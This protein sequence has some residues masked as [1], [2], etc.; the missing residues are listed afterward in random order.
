M[1]KVKKFAALF[2]ALT[3]LIC[4]YTG[5]AVFAVDSPSDFTIDE[6]GVLTEYSGAGGDVI[7]PDTVKEIG[8]Y[9]FMDCQSI[10]SVTIPEGVTKIQS[11]AFSDCT[12]LISGALPATLTA[13][14]SGAFYN[15]P[16]LSAIT[17]P[18]SSAYFCTDSAVLFSKDKTVLVLYPAALP[19]STYTV[20]TGVTKIADTAFSNAAN[21]TDVTLQDGVT[22][23]GRSAFALCQ[24]LANVSIP[25]SVTEIGG[26]AFEET[27]WLN[28]NT[29]PFVTV[30]NILVR[31]HGADS[32]AAVPADV[33]NIAE[34]AFFQCNVTSISIPNTV[35]KIGS[36]AFA[37]CLEL[38]SVSLPSSLTK[39]DDGLFAMCSKLNT[40]TIPAKVT[41]IGELAF[42]GCAALIN[43]NIPAHVS[44]IGG[45]AFISCIGLTDVI[46]PN[47]VTDIGDMAFA[48]CTNLKS[49][50]IPGSVT[51]I[52][53]SV[54]A[55]DSNV[56]VYG[57]AGSAAQTYASNSGFKFSPLISY[58][59][60]GYRGTVT[61]DTQSYDMAPKNIYDIGVKFAGNGNTKTFKVVSSR[62][63]I[64]SV[65]KL[66]NGNYRITGLK[67]GTT[68]IVCTIY[69]GTKEITHASI[70]VTVTAG[71]KQH[72][73]A[74]RS[75]SYFN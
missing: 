30:N 61:L 43:I 70:K 35:T 28:N 37:M 36:G 46:L 39:I 1:K 73:V 23:I 64:A 57:I 8:N 3:L 59:G 22:T 51:K 33:T 13:I 18:D 7:I 66:P 25:A 5:T 6:N 74:T 50:S 34:G 24:N 12:N 31:Y 60:T 48:A 17:V 29:N 68:Y 56:A 16:K 71:I 52:G 44:L 40:V 41:A 67:P 9:A 20:P 62:D 27:P 65:S 2:L 19:P 32:A 15:C 75:T 4:A 11:S 55:L 42:A 63:G 14:E 53:D 26:L 21:L 10:T 69:N 72:G 45:Q 49:I 54:F 47:G 58:K 38:T